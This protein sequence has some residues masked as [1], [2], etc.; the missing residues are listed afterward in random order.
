MD[1]FPEKEDAA[2]SHDTC[3]RHLPDPPVCSFFLQEREV[4]AMLDRTDTDIHASAQSV[5]LRISSA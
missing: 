1:R 5:T 3:R 2:E 4:T